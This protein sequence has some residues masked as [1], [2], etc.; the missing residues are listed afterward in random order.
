MAAPSPVR[1]P[2]AMGRMRSGA[3][4]QPMKP[5]FPGIPQRLRTKRIWHVMHDR[6]LGVAALLAL[7]VLLPTGSP[8][9][10]EAEAYAC[11]VYPYVPQDRG[12]Y[13][14]AQGAAECPRSSEYK[15][16]SVCLIKSGYGVISCRY[17]SGAQWSYYA[18][19]S[20]CADSGYYYTRPI[21]SNQSARYSGSV[22]IT[23]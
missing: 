23:C 1:D 10:G 5:V 3:T 6:P 4:H 12:A 13:A 18:A 19:S 14:L 11:S 17:D 16:L 8:F 2:P 20:G 21:L 15:T 22:F 7:A 9:V